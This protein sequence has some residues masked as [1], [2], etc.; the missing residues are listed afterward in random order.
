MYDGGLKARD[1]IRFW[2]NS[3]NRGHNCHK[4][5]PPVLPTRVLDLGPTPGVQPV[6]LWDT[7]GAKG[8]Y[9]AL[10]HSWGRGGKTILTTTQAT[11]RRHAEAGIP[12]KALPQTFLDVITIAAGLQIRYVW[13]DLLCIIQD[14]VSD[15]EREAPTMASVY[16]CAWLTVSAS[17]ALDATEG[18]FPRWRMFEYIP[19]ETRSTGT[20]Q[21]WNHL[22][23]V[24]VQ[25]STSFQ[26]RS[27]L[28]F[29]KSWMPPSAAAKPTVYRTGNFGKSY[30]PIASEPLS[31]RAWTLQERL[32]SARVLHFGRDQMYWQCGRCF[33]AEDGS[34]FDPGIFSLER[35]TTANAGG[36]T[37]ANGAP[38]ISF[39][40]EV[41]VPPADARFKGGWLQAVADYSVSRGQ[42]PRVVWSGRHHC[43]QDG[44]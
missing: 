20:L 18:C 24:P 36:P 44:G 13:I 39:V 35:V 27:Q 11:L 6:R 16:R 8:Q 40:P 10:S 31:S 15:W 22:N 19:T 4:K 42:T 14:S 37:G 28:F 34:R 5:E 33:A 17:H 2:I 30:D 1:I 26:R 43:V 7:R 21:T 3:C 32:L 25:A 38:F 23:Y 41:R 29:H 9:L 12:L